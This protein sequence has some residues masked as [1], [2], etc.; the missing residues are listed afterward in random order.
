MKT[1]KILIPLN[2]SPDTHDLMTDQAKSICNSLSHKCDLEIVWAIFPAV[3]PPAVRNERSNVINAAE[4]GN[5][6]HMIKT[7][8][9]D[10]VMINGSIDFHNVECNFVSK[11]L[12]IPTAVLFFRNRKTAKSLTKIQVLKSRVR[13]LFYKDEQSEGRKNW[14]RYVPFYFEQ[15]YYYFK[16]LLAANIGIWSSI[17]ILLK[18]FKSI[19]FTYNPVNSLIEGT[20]NFCADQEWSNELKKANFKDETIIVTGD[21]YYDNVFDDKK[22][23]KR[24][25]QNNEKKILVLFCTSA[26][27]NH[28]FCSKEQE[29]KFVIDVCNEIL[30]DK[31][32]ELS[33][34]IHPSTESLYDFE[35]FVLKKLSKQIKIFQKE[36][37]LNLITSN[38]VVVSYCGSGAIRDGVISGK[39]VIN[40][41]F[42]IA[43]QFFQNVYVD[44]KLLIQ[45][46]DINKLRSIIKENKSKMPLKSD[47]QNFLRKYVGVLDSKSSEICANEILKL[48]K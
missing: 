44:D 8:N 5:A 41:K 31:D 28:S 43:Q 12:K 33:L 45:C 21:P 37:L 4:Y 30:N 9:P 2:K 18:H 7:V 46:L 42:G 20:L 16:T 34:K 23:I 19:L 13:A 6:F 1:L 11:H 38:D 17:S 47:I 40:L 3:G 29:F 14:L 15:Y 39:P 25:A 22:E 35:N 27:S 26:L 24:Q 32:I 48:I 36:N 10:V